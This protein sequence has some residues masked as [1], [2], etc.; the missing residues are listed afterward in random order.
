MCKNETSFRKNRL[1]TLHSA[2]DCLPVPHPSTTS[3]AR[4]RGGLLNWACGVGVRRLD[5]C[6]LFQRKKPV[7]LR[8]YSSS[9]ARGRASTKIPVVVQFREYTR[10]A[11]GFDLW[12][13]S[14]NPPFGMVLCNL[15]FRSAGRKADQSTSFYILKSRQFFCRLLKKRTAGPFW[16]QTA[17]LPAHGRGRPAYTASRE[18]R[19]KTWPCKTWPYPL[20]GTVICLRHVLGSLEKPWSHWMGHSFRRNSRRNRR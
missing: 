10:L 14:V 20:P 8:S 13:T 6:T 4:S 1:C 16:A 9:W 2:S 18:G 15:P 5:V 12:E 3:S 19:V 7:K 11:I 17:P